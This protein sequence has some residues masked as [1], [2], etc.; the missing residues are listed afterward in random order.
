[1]F[2]FE[3]RLTL[4]GFFMADWVLAI[5]TVIGL[6]LLWQ[7]NRILARQALSVSQS[8]R[9]NMHRYWPM[10][11]MALLML[12]VWAGVGYDSYERH[13]FKP[14]SSTSPVASPMT[15]LVQGFGPCDVNI[16]GSK[17]IGELLI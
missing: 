5:A 9:L 2:L 6:G 16:D 10:A 8:E 11:V 17:L 3:D 1:M 12:G 14:A 15:G 4:E 13:Y 7:Q